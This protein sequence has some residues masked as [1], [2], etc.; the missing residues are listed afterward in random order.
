MDAP[1]ASPNPNK[2][3]QF[4]IRVRGQLGAEWAEWFGGLSVT[5]EVGSDTLLRGVVADQA[6]L[7]GVLRKVRDLG[8]PLLAV[9]CVG[10]PEDTGAS[11][12]NAP[13][14]GAQAR[15]DRDE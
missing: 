11:A 10:E 5:Q 4:E 1:L 3:L 2:A 14:P 13:L 12:E 8:L 15:A 7:Y 6:A 9:N